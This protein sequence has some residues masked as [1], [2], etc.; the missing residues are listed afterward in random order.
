M[1][2]GPSPRTRS[3]CLAIAA[4]GAAVILVAHAFTVKAFLLDWILFPIVTLFVGL[5][6]RRTRGD[7]D[8]CIAGV[9]MVLFPFGFSWVVTLDPSMPLMESGRRG[10]LFIIVASSAM[11]GMIVGIGMRSPRSGIAATLA[12]FGS[13]LGMLLISRDPML[14]GTPQIMLGYLLPVTI[15]TI[16]ALRVRRDRAHARQLAWHASNHCSNCG[17]NLH[18]G[19]SQT[20]PECGHVTISNEGVKCQWCN[21]DVSKVLGDRCPKCEGFARPQPPHVQDALDGELFRERR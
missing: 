12:A 18:G 8:L 14:H 2:S 4:A 21:Y 9:A 16:L 13:I 7:L 11:L 3:I 1:M 5:A 19:E 10:L 20:C 6:T 17:Y 15:L